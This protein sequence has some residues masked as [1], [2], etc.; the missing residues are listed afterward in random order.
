MAAEFDT[1]WTL[2]GAIFSS[3]YQI[4]WHLPQPLSTFLQHKFQ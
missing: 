4:I 2:F 3:H 1:L